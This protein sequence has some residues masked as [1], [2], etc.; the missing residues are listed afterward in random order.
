MPV[1]VCNPA[2]V[3]VVSRPVSEG[4]DQAT[5]QHWWVN[6]I[7]AHPVSTHDTLNSQAL[8]VMS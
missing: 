6:S 4:L 5:E 1:Q 2:M 8:V 3:R 7:T